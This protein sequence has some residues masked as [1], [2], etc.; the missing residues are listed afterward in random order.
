MMARKHPNLPSSLPPRGLS[1]ELASLYIGVSVTKFDQLV[2]E[3]R[4][5]AAKRI[6]GRKLW[7]REALDGAFWALPD[8]GPNRLDNPWDEAA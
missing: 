5:P 8:D 6:D 4:M 1:R 2:H 7:D 3:G